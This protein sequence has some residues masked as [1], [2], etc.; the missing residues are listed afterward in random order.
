MIGD[1]MR[2]FIGAVLAVLLQVIVCPNI[3]IFNAMPNLLVIYALM[4]AM[5]VPGS[6]HVILAFCLGLVSDLMGY[7]PVG[8]MSL[9]LILGCAAASRVH[10]AFA[11][12]TLFIPLVV[13]AVF[14]LLIELFYAFIAIGVSGFNPLDAFVYRALPCT[15]YNCVIGLVLYPLLRKV[16]EDNQPQFSSVT[17]GPHLD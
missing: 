6:S 10:A 16:F 15:L 17:P 5:L 9:L 4:V 2:I 11:N 13:M 7:G 1:N 3:A 12:G 8:A 14:V